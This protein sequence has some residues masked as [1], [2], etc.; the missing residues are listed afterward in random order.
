[1]GESEAPGGG[2]GS[3][4]HWKSQGGEGF[5]DGE[6]PRAWEGVCGKLGD[7]GGGLNI[8]LQGRNVHQVEI[9]EML[10]TQESLS[11]GGEKNQYHPFQSHYTHGV[12]IFEF[13]R[14]LH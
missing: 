4:S 7:F 12:I 10:G 11:V 8:F 14:G 2:V 9:L 6:G 13:F 5:Q 1:M 3:V